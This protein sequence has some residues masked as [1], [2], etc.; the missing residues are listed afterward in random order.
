MRKGATV[1]SIKRG[2]AAMASVSQDSVEDVPSGVN[3]ILFRRG[4]AAA[5]SH[6]WSIHRRMMAYVVFTIVL[7]LTSETNFDY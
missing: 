6:D 1:L 2:V 5:P 3:D 7:L 4:L